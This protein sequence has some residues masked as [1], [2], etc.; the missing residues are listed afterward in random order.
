[1]WGGVLFPDEMRELARL[2][3]KAVG[4]ADDLPDWLQPAEAEPLPTPRQAARIL[5]L[6]RRLDELDDDEVDSA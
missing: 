2:A 4:S 6:E 5:E 1:M 3:L